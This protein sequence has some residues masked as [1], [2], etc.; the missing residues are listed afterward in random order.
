MDVQGTQGTR[1]VHL[2]NDEAPQTQREYV[3]AFREL[4]RGIG[5]TVDRLAEN[6]HLDRIMRRRVESKGEKVTDDLI[7]ME[8]TNLIEAINDPKYRDS[9]LVA[10]RLDLRYQQRALTDRRKKYNEDL[11]HA[12]DAELRQLHVDSART[13]E[14]RENRAI[15]L[16]A[17]Y[18][19]E[20]RD[21]AAEVPH[22]DWPLR[23]IAPKGELAVEAISQTCS[24]S[25]TGVM[26]SQDV[27][28]WVRATS[29]VTNPELTVTHRYFNE[30]KSGLIRVESLY[31]CLVDS[32][33]ETVSG[34]FIAKLRIHRDL[35][36]AD[37]IYAF[38]TRVCINS[39]TRCRPVVTW[40]PRS[41][42]TRRI[43]FHLKFH[44][45]QKPARAWWFQSS[46]DVEGEIEPPAHEGRHLQLLDEGRYLYRIF[47]H[48]HIT[49]SLRYGISWIWPSGA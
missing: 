46:R 20:H 43:E 12:H 17:R 3:R 19:D 8:I 35:D 11:K 22:R 16:V 18:L 33:A 49:P 44:D 10:L 39:D 29:S 21:T 42:F 36:P 41:G 40:R 30:N 14:R 47:E 2:V 38:A 24:F 6:A 26:T 1:R 28:R 32:Q 48:E 23:P 45:S 25:P 7:I 34:D 27:H 4:R 9:L 37:G 15:A 13:M 5:C 31:G